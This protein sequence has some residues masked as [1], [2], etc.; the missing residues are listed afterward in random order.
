MNNKLI[1]KYTCRVNN[2]MIEISF[3]KVYDESDDYN[4][5]LF[6]LSNKLLINKLSKAT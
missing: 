6:Y 1:N 5:N 3:S 2:Q 4:R